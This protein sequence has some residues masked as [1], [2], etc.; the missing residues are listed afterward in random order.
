MALED[1]IRLPVL[2][3]I[4]RRQRLLNMLT[5]FVETDKRLITVYAPG[6]YGKSILLADFAQT[7]D[8]PVCWCSLEPADRDPTAFLTLLAYSITDRFRELEADG[9]LSL[10]EKGDTQASVRRIADSLAEVGPHLI[11]IDDY[12]KAVSAGMTLALNRLLEQ[13]PQTSTII[14]AARGDMMLETSQVIDLLIA[15]RAT[16]LSEEELRFTPPELQRVMR[17]RF[18][19]QIDLTTAETI[20]RATDG[21]IAQILLTGHVMHTD[22]LVSRLGQRLGD[23]QAVIYDYLAE[24][25]LDKQS[26]ELQR[27]LLYTSVL[28]DMTPEVCNEL[29]EITNAQACL[30]ELVHKD[31]FIT[32]VGV[33]FRYHDLFAEFLQA[34]LAEDE[35]LHR[36]VSIKAAHIL[37]AR[38]RDEEAIS[39]FISGQAWNQAIALLTTKGGSFYETGRALT[40]HD[41]LAEIP[42][43]KLARHPRLLLLRGQILNN[44]LSDPES[45][46][47]TFRKAEKQFLEQDDLIGAAEAQVWQ[48]VSLRIMGRAQESLALAAKGLEQLEALKVDQQRLAWAIRQRGVAY[49][50]VGKSSDALSDLRRAL[51][52]FEAV[53]DTYNIGLCHHDTGIALARQGNVDSANHHFGQAVQIWETLANDSHLAN[54]LNS[55][56]VELYRIG[57][58]DQALKHFNDCLEITARTRAIVTTAYVQTGIGDVYLA[59]QEYGRAV[60][61][62]QTSIDMARRTGVTS[63]EI[64]NMVQLGECSYQQGQLTEAVALADEA[65]QIATEMGLTFEKGLACML[66]AKVFVRRTLKDSL[67]LFAEA[68]ACFS[69]N[70]VLEQ[71]KV[72]L[73]WGYALFLD[74]RISAAYEQ[75]QAAIELALNMGKLRAG[76]QKT[77]V[78][79]QQVLL[80]FRYRDDMPRVVRDNIGLLM[81]ERPRYIKI[82]PGL[83]VFAF[84]RP[85]LIIANEFKYF[86]GI[87]GN[88]RKMPELLLYLILEGEKRWLRWSEVAAAIWPDLTSDKASRNFH[89]TIRRFR[90]GVLGSPDYIITDRDYYQI[91]KSELKWCD[92]LACERLFERAA[93]APPEEALVWQLEMISLYQG[94]FLAGFELGEWG[95]IYRARYEDQFLQVV[96]LASGQMIQTGEAQQALSLIKTGLAQNYFREDLHRRAAEAY[97]QLGLRD[98]LAKHYLELCRTFEEELG[99]PPSAETRR[100]FGH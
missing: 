12:H 39:L 9:L 55:L 6:G 64:Y 75:I 74:L 35:A 20:A 2:N 5:E 49:E 76:L 47:T 56:A 83:Q 36:Q 40:L 62:Y 99:V 28:P 90:R 97:L 25:V 18:G 53:G 89:Q 8:L 60:E 31:L 61:A 98:D 4:H 79:T 14:V 85:A 38:S 24:E 1:R 27:F 23:D 42:E 72:R 59:L 84:G 19:R 80:H 100:A 26:S 96:T 71:V 65:Q 50:N 37:Q 70:D 43:P 94:E 22:R 68:L 16:G 88:V 87:R 41:W 10:V 51:Q 91:N 13:L 73:W 66:H 21:N 81:W 34:K 69:E 93:A 63:V 58:Y 3:L 48:S 29:L 52:L 30:E 15:E 44:D 46:I 78:E 54:T 86:F 7:T 45:A 11:I 67:S 17:K 33:S 77:I 92:A 32:Q 95:M 57:Q 82:Q